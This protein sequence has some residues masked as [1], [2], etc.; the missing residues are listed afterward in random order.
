MFDEEGESNHIVGQA[1][2]FGKLLFEMATDALP[3]D[4]APYRVLK[5]VW[6]SCYFFLI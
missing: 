2:T 1:K 4:M 3:F 6:L 5:P